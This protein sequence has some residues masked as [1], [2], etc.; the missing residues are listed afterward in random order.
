MRRSPPSWPQRPTPRCSPCAPPQRAR[1][2]SGLWLALLLVSGLSLACGSRRAAER[3]AARPVDATEARVQAL[4]DAARAQPTAPEGWQ[5]AIEELERL[6]DERGALELCEQALAAAGER[7]ELLELATS[8]AEQADDPEPA[9]K[10]ATRLQTVRPEDPRVLLRIAAL[11]ARAGRHAAARRRL[12]HPPEGRSFRLGPLQLTRGWLALYA[13]EPARARIFA[14]LARAEDEPE[15]L[16]LL[17]LLQAREGSL[18]G[19]LELLGERLRDQPGDHVAGLLL[20][21]VLLLGGEAERAAERL[22]ALAS[23]RPRSARLQLWAGLARSLAGERDAARHLF[24]Q[25]LAL[26]DIAAH[27]GLAALAAD[28]D[29]RRRRHLEVYLAAQPDAPPHHPA[30]ALLGDGGRP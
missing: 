1:S 18:E 29:D 14:T 8:V 23:A 12:Q 15:A 4:V 20:G 7:P 13:G 11:E 21:Q 2:R 10:W 25:A 30:R 26:D 27:L 22:C 19:A 5:R 24:T 9:L 28:G 6:G 17:A 16:L 3:P